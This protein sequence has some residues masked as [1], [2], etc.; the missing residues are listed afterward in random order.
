MSLQN[1]YAPVRFRSS[2]PEA[3]VAKLAN[4]QD[5]KSCDPKGLVGSSPTPGTKVAEGYFDPEQAK[6]LTNRKIFWRSK[7]PFQD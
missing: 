6:N 4:A 7:G 1:S 2:P 5:L 3:G